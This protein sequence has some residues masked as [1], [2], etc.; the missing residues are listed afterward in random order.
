MC[1][2]MTDTIPNFSI[3]IAFFIPSLS[4]YGFFS[5]SSSPWAIKAARIFSSFASLAFYF[6]LV[7]SILGFG[8]A[9]GVKTKTQP[10][11]L[12]LTI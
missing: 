6:P 9:P 1:L 5:A 8:L 3:P 11:L 10:L 4:S 12:F 2:L 7:L